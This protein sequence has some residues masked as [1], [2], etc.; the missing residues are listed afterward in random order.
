MRDITLKFKD[1]NEYKNF[2]IGINWQENEDLQN[3][4]ILDEIGFTYTDTSISDEQTYIRNEGYFI[5]VRIIDNSFNDYIFDEYVV[6]L[7][8]PLRE[9]A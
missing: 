6:T 1:Q 3:K 7:D 8:Q 5:N 9:W 4:I 2:L